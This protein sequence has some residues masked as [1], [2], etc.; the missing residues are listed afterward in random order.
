M[1]W[2]SLLKSLVNLV[3]VAFSY[4][5][6]DKNDLYFFQVNIVMLHFLIFI[7]IKM[8]F[9]FLNCPPTLLELLIPDFVRIKYTNKFFLLI[10]NLFNFC[11]CFNHKKKIVFKLN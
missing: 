1:S 4:I 9:T 8:T 11:R 10:I 5:H 2:I 3:M 7:L 6:F